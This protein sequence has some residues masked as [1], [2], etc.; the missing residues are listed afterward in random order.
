MNYIRNFR[1]NLIIAL[2][3]KANR[4]H[5]LWTRFFLLDESKQTAL[6]WGMAIICIGL[7]S[8]V[9]NWIGG[10]LG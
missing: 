8:T 1:D 4:G 9:W 10:L 7:I 2:K 3:Q 6:W 5:W